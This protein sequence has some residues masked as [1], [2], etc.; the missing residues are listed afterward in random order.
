MPGPETFAPSQQQTTES[1]LITEVPK[2][3]EPTQV[4]ELESQQAQAPIDAL[5]DFGEATTDVGVIFE[6]GDQAAIDARKQEEQNEQLD[7]L[8]RRR[9]VRTIYAQVIPES[10]QSSSQSPQLAG[11]ESYVKYIPPEALQ[12]REKRR[13]LLA[14]LALRFSKRTP[15]AEQTDSK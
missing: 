9:V 5:P 3:P 12:P 13:G 4:Q 6:P 2:N 10:E 11:N 15:S 1:T 7:K 8:S 14:R